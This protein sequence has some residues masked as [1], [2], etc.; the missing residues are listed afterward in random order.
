MV[1][2][3]YC[4]PSVAAK[5][6]IATP[7]SPAIAIEI[8]AS[9]F[10]SRIVDDKVRRSE[11]PTSNVNIIQKICLPEIFI[12]FLTIHLSPY[13]FIHFSLTVTMVRIDPLA[14]WLD[15]HGL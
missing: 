15:L 10:A 7:T 8:Q 11:F 13:C 2:F 6:V 9:C 3:G 14:E 12:E 1:W 4:E 5:K